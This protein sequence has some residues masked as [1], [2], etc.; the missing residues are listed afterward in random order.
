M[1][2]YLLLL[3]KLIHQN[4]WRLVFIILLPFFLLLAIVPFVA[5]TVEQSEVPIAWVADEETDMIQ[6]LAKRI[7]EHPRILLF[8][9]NEEEAYRAVSTQEVEAAFMLNPN[10]QDDI[11]AGKIRDQIIWIRT[12]NSVL[13]TF[14][15]EKV[16]AEVMR[17]TLN[18]KAANDLAELT[19][20]SSEEQ[21]QTA[22]EHSDS[23]WEPEPLF[24]M[25]FVSSRNEAEQPLRENA[26]D[27]QLAAGLFGFW[28][29]YAW[30]IFAIQLLVLDQWKQK[31]LFIR[32]QVTSG[33]LKG[34]YGR[35]Y[36]LN[37]IF[38]VLILV[39]IC[40]L[41]TLKLPISEGPWIVN[42]FWIL[43]AACLLTILLRQVLWKRNVFL[44]VGIVYSL[45]SYLIGVLTMV[46]DSE[47]WWQQ[48]LPHVWF[49]QLF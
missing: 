6:T 48:F 19:R 10:F 29:W 31:G 14:V 16:A 13:D 37:I 28:I 7:D 24:Q 45:S 42:S 20:N 25:E 5:N 22:F 41:T 26:I 32:L 46:S 34:F 17:F 43:L 39:A 33:S 21:W 44:M 30:I 23:Y 12:E 35:F 2:T 15:K 27:D 36:L 3:H 1:G 38:S 40:M 18:S 11:T 4:K 9:L 8:H 49:Y 47:H